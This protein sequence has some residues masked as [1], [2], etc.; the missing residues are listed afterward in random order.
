MLGKNSLM[1]AQRDLGNS[2]LRTDFL[3]SEYKEGW[4]CV[5]TEKRRNIYRGIATL[6]IV[7]PDGIKNVNNTA[8]CNRSAGV[9]SV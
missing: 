7:L 1:F 6:P 5:S 3:M 2:P 4:V 9:S 8:T